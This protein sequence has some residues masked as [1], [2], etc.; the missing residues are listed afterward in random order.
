M[1]HYEPV[2]LFMSGA[3]TNLALALRMEPEISEKIAAVYIMGGAVNVPGNIKGLLPDSTNSSAE[4]NIYAD[5]LAASEVFTSGLNLYLVPLDATNQLKL[6]AR[7]TAVWRKGGS[8][9]DFAADI[10]ESLMEAWN[11]DEVEIWDLVTAE[12]MLNPQ[13]CTFTPLRLEVV[14]DDG[15]TQGQTRVV[16]G[17]SNVNVCLDPDSEAIKQELAKVFSSRK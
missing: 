5:P 13:H 12:I 15:E 10:Y 7:D 14:T 16:D 11:V 2:T 17:E 8:I 1:Q 6:T 4:W 9:P 3:L